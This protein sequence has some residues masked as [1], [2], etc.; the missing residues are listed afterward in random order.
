MTASPRQITARFR[1]RFDSVDALVLTYTQDISQGRLFVR[2]TSTLE[3][4]DLVHVLFDLED[5]EPP[6]PA[7]ARVTGTFG[8]ASGHE[9]GVSTELVTLPPGLTDRITRHLARQLDGTASGEAAESAR[10]L[11]VEDSSSQRAHVART[12]ENLGHVVH[13]AGDGLQGLGAIMR[14]VPDLVLCDVQ[15]PVM[16]GWQLLRVVRSKPSIAHVPIVFLTDLASEQDR[17]EG[18]RLGV[19]DYLSKPF[20]E[21]E[22]RLRIDRV[23]RRTRVRS[24]DP[25]TFG[26]LRGDL[27]LVS[28][29]SVLAFLHAERR[30]GLLLIASDARLAALHIREGNVRRVDLSGEPPAVDH[31][32]RLFGLLDWTRGWFELTP[33]DIDGADAIAMTTPELLLEHARLSDESSR[34]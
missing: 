11:L 20:A 1:V 13:T 32:P 17:L 27:S 19:D 16:T 14:E 23:L 4:G 25:T 24:P 30:T 2:T 3:T 34:G 29:P 18:Y 15:M 9:P 22:L 12:L 6:E 31:T 5:G 10:I 33:D 26:K 28:L 21:E 7:V 8:P